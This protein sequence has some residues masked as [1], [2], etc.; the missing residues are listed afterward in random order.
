VHNEAARLHAGANRAPYRRFFALHSPFL[1]HC[2]DAAR[3]NMRRIAPDQDA[4]ARSLFPL[5]HAR[6]LLLH[7]SRITR[8]LA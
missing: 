4:A 8:A 7:A 5:R 1:A 3:P 6:A 2:N